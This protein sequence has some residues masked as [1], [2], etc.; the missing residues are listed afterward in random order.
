RPA[1]TTLRAGS[2]EQPSEVACILPSLVQGGST[3]QLSARRPERFVRDGLNVGTASNNVHGGEIYFLDRAHAKK[4]KKGL[5]L[6]LVSAI[7]HVSGSTFGRLVEPRRS[8]RS[9]L[10]VSI[11]L[12]F[13]ER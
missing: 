13:F 11:N 2:R 12:P 9:Q 8:R 6:V 4:R 3:V 5:A 1:A 10:L 7:S